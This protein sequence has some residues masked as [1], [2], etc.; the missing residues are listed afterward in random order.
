MTDHGAGSEVEAAREREV[1]DLDAFYRHLGEFVCEYARLEVFCHF[2]FHK[3][4]GLD[5]EV[6]QSI[7]GGMRLVDLI[8]AL[9]RVIEL[10]NLSGVQKDD[11]RLCMAQLAHITAFRHRLIHRGARAYEGS[12]VS[13][14][15]AIAKSPEGREVL[16]FNVDDVKAAAADCSRITWRLH[17]INDPHFRDL[18]SDSRWEELTGPWLYKPVQPRKSNQP[19]P[20]AR[21]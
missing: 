16:R 8:G 6:A 9:N 10:G 11:F 18:I 5:R 2:T 12:F 21:Q 20:K 17:L 4:C 7:A 1:R 15:S 13:S 14:N 19:H 3:Q